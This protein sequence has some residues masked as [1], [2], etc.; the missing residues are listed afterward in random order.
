MHRVPL[1]RL[2]ALP[3]LVAPI[4]LDEPLK[5]KELPVPSGSLKDMR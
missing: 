4:V 2:M 5:S 1:L 3:L